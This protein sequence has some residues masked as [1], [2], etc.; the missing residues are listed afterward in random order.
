MD[1]IETRARE[2][3]K[4]EDSHSS[5]ESVLLKNG[6]I[7]GATEQKAIDDEKYRNDMKAK[8]DYYIDEIDEMADRA[9]RLQE[10]LLD[11][12]RERAKAW[13]EKKFYNSYMNENDHSEGREVLFANDE[14]SVESLF[15]DF[16]KSIEDL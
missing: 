15:E 10:K 9:V 2:W 6:Y 16:C 4:F 5:I 1:D 7:H 13:F 3:S 11:D 12:V 8:D 14:Y